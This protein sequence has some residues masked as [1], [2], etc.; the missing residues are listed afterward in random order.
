MGSG[1]GAGALGG[2]LRLGRAHLGMRL[3]PPAWRW[4]EG[5]YDAFSH[6]LSRLCIRLATV[7]MILACVLPGQRK[8][9]EV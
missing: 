8:E 4:W 7:V 2:R 5:R 6:C 3:P 1:G 9:A